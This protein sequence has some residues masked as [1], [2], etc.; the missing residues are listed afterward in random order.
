[1]SGVAFRY[2]V[3]QKQLGALPT[4]AD[5]LG[6]PLSTLSGLIGGTQYASESMVATI[7]NGLGVDEGILFPSL[8]GFIDPPKTVRSKAAA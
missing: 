8:I 4:V 2:V 3:R 5:D 7:C 1:M 6:V